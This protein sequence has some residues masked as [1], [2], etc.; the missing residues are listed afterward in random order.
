MFIIN[1]QGVNK[2]L[3]FE[4]IPFLFHQV[5][6][7]LTITWFFML[8]WRL[9]ISHSSQKYVSKWQLNNESMS[10]N[11]GLRWF[12]WTSL[13]LIKIEELSWNEFDLPFYSFNKKTNSYSHFG[14]YQIAA[15]FKIDRHLAYV[16]SYRY[17]TI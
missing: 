1:F 9:Q 6:P 5:F 10:M 13:N 4:M 14:R 3:Y 15:N 11:E 2:P 17:E 8:K 7:T 12:V 16:V